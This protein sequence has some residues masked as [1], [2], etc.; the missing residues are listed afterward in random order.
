MKGT[1]STPD[2]GRSE[3]E[4][5][6]RKNRLPGYGW[7]AQLSGLS[8][9]REW[10]GFFIVTVAVFVVIIVGGYILQAVGVW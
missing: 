3:V 4:K 2:S 1:D 9:R 5:K 6:P 10:Q 8:R 7:S